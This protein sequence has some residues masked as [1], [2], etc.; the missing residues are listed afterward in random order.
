[1]HSKQ[2]TCQGENI[3]K[4]AWFASVANVAQF[5]TNVHATAHTRGLKNPS[6]PVEFD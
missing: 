2:V 3:I 4:R 6:E 1:M 5:N